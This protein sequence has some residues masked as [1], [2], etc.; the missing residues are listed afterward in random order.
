MNI[1]S[2][3]KQPIIVA[4]YDNGIRKKIT[5]CPNCY[6]VLDENHKI[7]YCT[8]CKQELEWR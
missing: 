1:E 4:F 3:P 6:E 5:E 2:N 8:K 7:K